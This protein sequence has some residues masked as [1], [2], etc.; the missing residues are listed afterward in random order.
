MASSVP[1]S[2]TTEKPAK[3]D[4]PAYKPG[5]L[6][7][8]CDHIRRSIVGP[9]SAFVKN[10]KHALSTICN[11]SPIRSQHYKDEKGRVV[12]RIGPLYLCLQCESTLPEEQIDK[13]SLETKHRLCMS[14]CKSMFVESRSGNLFCNMCKDFVFDPV[15]ESLR[16]RKVETG[17]YS[18]K[19]KHDEY[20]E[21]FQENTIKVASKDASKQSC[22]VATVR[23]IWNMGSTC[24]MTVIL[25]SLVHNPLMRNFYLSEG[26]KSSTCTKSLNNEP[27]LS[28]FM[29]DMFQQF[30]NT[31]TTSAWTAQNILGSFVFSAKPAY[32]SIKP[33]EQQDAH[34]FLNFLLEELHEINSVD[35]RSLIANSSPN[36]RLKYDGEDC[37]C[38]IH[39]TFYGKTLSIIRCKGVNNGKKCGSVRRTGLQQFSDISLGLDFL[40]TQ[41]S[42]K[43]HSLEYCLKK[44]YFTEE[45]CDYS[46]DACGSKKATKQVS[47]KMLPNVLCF[48]L[49]RFSQKGGNAIKI[50]NKVSFPFKLEMLPY[51][52][53]ID[54]AKGHGPAQYA[55]K[56][57]STY[58]LQSVV[59]HIGDAIEQGHYISYSKHDNQWFKFDDHKVYTAS[60]SEVLG[61]EAYLLFYVIQSMATT[62]EK[63]K[64]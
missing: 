3:S 50:K 58:H 31:E 8:G 33:D 12:S 59:T 9:N 18:L 54:E 15:L 43:K 5:V 52:D 64:V 60:K 46:C 29:D 48:Q 56:A 4:I 42:T 19:R 61:V 16:T 41:A 62:E 7:Y 51:T 45:Q 53:K 2:P 37:K 28:C 6:S 49:K 55:L 24:Y 36:K 32:E 20:A 34:E 1:P 47:I 63:K 17:S 44:E 10:Y 11:S 57:R 30:N 22:S 39:Q 13:H 23:G 40:S 21:L 38:V 35:P 25:E 26:H 27:C 14:T